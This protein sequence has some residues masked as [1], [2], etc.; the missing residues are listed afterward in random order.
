MPRYRS[1]KTSRTARIVYTC[2]LAG[3]A[4]CGVAV[5][6]AMAGG[7][8]GTIVIKDES[9]GD[10][11]MQKLSFKGELLRMEEV[12]AHADGSA[13]IFNGQTK[14]SFLIDVDEHAY[15]PLTWPPSLAEDLQKEAEPVVVTKTGKRDN[16]AGYACDLY[17]EKDTLSGG[18]SELCIAHGLSSSGLFG[19]S[20]SDSP[21]ASLLPSWLGAMVKDGA[22]PVRG[23]ERDKAGKEVSR[24]EATKIE[25]KKLDA[26]LFAPPPGYRRMNMEEVGG[27]GRAHDR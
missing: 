19:L 27:G 5:A 17:L 11:T 23:I 6:P 14:E 12:G 3:V 13:M 4:V 20:G 22:F 21:I 10:A 15:F 16:V 18:V 24:F 2:Y 26:K 25:A 1:R 8:E 7:F 9:G